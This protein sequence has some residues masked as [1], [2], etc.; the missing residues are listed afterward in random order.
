V[1][2]EFVKVSCAV[3]A[4]TLLES[5]LF[6]HV[7]GAFTGAI[8]DK[9]GRFELAEKGTIFL[10]EIGEVGPAAQ[11]K[12]LRVLQEKEIERVGE[13]KPTKVDTRVIAATNK[14]LKALLNTG[15]FR[16]DLFYRLNVVS[17]NLPPLRE[18]GDDIPL[19]VNHFIKKFN[20][21][22]KKKIKGIS[23]ETRDILMENDWG[24]NIR[25]LENTIEHAFVKSHSSIITPHDIPH[26]V[27]IAKCLHL[28]NQEKKEALDYQ[29]LLDALKKSGWNQSKAARK[30]RVNRITIWRNIKKYGIDIPAQ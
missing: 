22:Y 16:E 5:E 28:P 6:G 18:R 1:V 12:L 19:V 21:Q 13:Y 30:L 10:D 3:L 9:K 8:R 24:G 27:R 20:K 11:V 29:S 2:R 15:K 4:E 17:I 23:H 25:E 14:D 7:K 26:E